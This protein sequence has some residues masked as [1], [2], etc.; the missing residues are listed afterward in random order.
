MKDALHMEIHCKADLK[1]RV[2]TEHIR[3]I[4]L[5]NY[6]VSDLER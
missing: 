3:S 6:C 5:N 1:K 4:L 2:L